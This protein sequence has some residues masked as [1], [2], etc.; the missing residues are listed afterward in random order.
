[1]VSGQIKIP[2]EIMEPALHKINVNVTLAGQDYRV[3]KLYAT[4]YHWHNFRIRFAQG[5]ATV[6]PRTP[7]NVILDGPEVTA[8]FKSPAI[9]TVEIMELV[10]TYRR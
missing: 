9:M 10:F 4:A 3:Q 7:V 1:M 5:M 2:V 6:S 8:I